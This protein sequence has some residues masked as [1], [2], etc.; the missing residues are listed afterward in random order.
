MILVFFL[1]LFSFC[2]YNFNNVSINNDITTYLPENTETKYSLD[3]MNKEY[4]TFTSINLMVENINSEY[5]REI[6]EKLDTIK[7]IKNISY[8]EK[9]N[10]R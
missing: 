7:E 4:G 3:L 8:V 5:S 9:N 1:M 6:Y 10:K 2:L